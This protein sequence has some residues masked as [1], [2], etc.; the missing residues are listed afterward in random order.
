MIHQ[1]DSKLSVFYSMYFCFII[2]KIQGHIIIQEEPNGDRTVLTMAENGN[3]GQFYKES[4]QNQADEEKQKTIEEFIQFIP[5]GREEEEKSKN[6]QKSPIDQVIEHSRF[7]Q[8][9]CIC[10]VTW[11]KL[12]FLVI[13]CFCLFVILFR[14]NVIQII[15]YLS[16]R[17]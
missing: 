11:L 14:T 12:P 5:T 6:T 16:R 1:I 3:D 17:Q 7:E 4:K 10:W 15:K 9:S 2:S 8:I 13:S